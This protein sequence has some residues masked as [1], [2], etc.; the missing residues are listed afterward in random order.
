MS[1]AKD[2][3]FREWVS[4]QPSCISGGYSEWVNGEGRNIACHIRRVSRGAGTG[5]KPLFSCVPMTNEEHMNTHRFGE[6]YYHWPEWFDKKAD[7]Y[8]AMWERLQ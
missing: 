6:E 5:I 4:R 7:E 1:R 3:K 2:K 8:L